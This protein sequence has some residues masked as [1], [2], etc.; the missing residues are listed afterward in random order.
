MNL[1]EIR[2]YFSK[3]DLLALLKLLA[4]PAGLVFVIFLLWAGSEVKERLAN[5]TLPGLRRLA[6]KELLPG[7]DK[8]AVISFLDRNQIGHGTYEPVTE[9][10]RQ[11]SM[12]FDDYK[13]KENLSRI[14]YRINGGR[15]VSNWRWVLGCWMTIWVYFDEEGKLIDYQLHGFCDG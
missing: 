7:T 6:E 14:R 13:I 2:Y 3:D 10:E 1:S 8:A 5:P 4:I 12:E 15:D 9:N 11:L